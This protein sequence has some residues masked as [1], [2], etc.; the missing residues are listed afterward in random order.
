MRIARIAKLFAALVAGLLFHWEVS[1]Q[2]ITY[3]H[4]DASGTP[5]LA[6]DGSG[7][8]VWKENYRPYGERLLNQTAAT[9]N[10]IGF[11][12]QPF[13][14]STGLSYMGARYYDPVLGRFLGVDPAEVDADNVN[15]FNRYAYGANNPYRYVDRDGHSPVDVVF[16]L[17]DLGKLGV[18]AYSGAD[19]AGAAFD[20]AISAVGVVSPIPG[21]GVAIKAARAAERSIE[22][23]LKVERSIETGRAAEV[24][25]V[26]AKDAAEAGRAGRQ[27]R[28]R[29]LANDDKLG[30]ADR[31]WIKQEL[32]S[33]ERGQRSTI[34]NPPGKELAHERGR[35]SAKGYDYGHS[36]LQDR[37]LHRLQHKYDDFGRANTER[38]L[39]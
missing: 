32:N 2:V 17:Y 5:L 13:E 29:D 26:A 28:L 27:A 21:T 24:S 30:A 35:E 12:G 36:N 25:L 14:S 39:P 20:V 3:F 15:G 18:A 22:V 1:A 10:K 38:P 11:A 34:R 33:I 31:G 37:D 4:S 19:V 23:A 16:L 8:V 7:T 9:D 6:T